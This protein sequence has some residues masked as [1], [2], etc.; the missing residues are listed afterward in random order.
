MD[1]PLKRFAFHFHKCPNVAEARMPDFETE[2]Q[3]FGGDISLC[4][5]SLH[6]E[7]PCICKKPYQF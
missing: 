4:F 3:C 1:G 6:F 2:S 5:S 7:R